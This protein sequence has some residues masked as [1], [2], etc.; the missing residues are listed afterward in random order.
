MAI[1]KIRLKDSD[2]YVVRDML[3]E[4]IGPTAVRAVTTYNGRSVITFEAAGLPNDLIF[5]IH[6]KIRPLLKHNFSVGL[7]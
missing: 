4:K 1:L 2:Q 6:S 7:P 5:D 3:A